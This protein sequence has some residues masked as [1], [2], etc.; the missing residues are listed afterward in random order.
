[1]L[2][3]VNPSTDP[4]FNLA[5]EEYLLRNFQENCFML[6][7]NENSV[8]VGKHQNTLA[9]IN[10]HFVKE[11]NIRIARRISGGGTVYH[12]LG[13]LNFTFIM[14]GEQG[15]LVDFR[16]HTLPIL[17]I[18]HKL[19]VNARF[20]GRND[21]AIGDKKI[22]GNAEHVYRKRVLHHG[23]LL[24]SSDL[25]DLDLVLKVNPLKY[26]S[27]AVKSIRSQVTNIRDHLK[28]SLDIL[29]FRDL[30]MKHVMSRFPGSEYYAF[31]REDTNLIN[32]LKANKYDT[33][34][35][36]YGYSP[37]YELENTFLMNGR[38][39]ILRL[40]V[41]GGIIIKA[42]ISGDL[43]GN[44]PVNDLE[45]ALEGVRHD[46]DELAAKLGS[47]TF[48]EGFNISNPGEFARKYLL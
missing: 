26:K 24:F 1:M 45:K 21:L 23:T 34:E 11:K 30:I 5:A 6:W 19:S 28:T 7:R 40:T 2:C 12:D 48:P 41:S 10:H 8:V 35:W 43:Q 33:W 4:Y 42:T 46:E 25:D 39:M 18:L 15:R 14:D 9:E 20:R 47:V 36:I 37:E 16:K 22:S 3:I 31:T 29:Q 32:Q 38:H 27:K 13:N 17:E 44:I